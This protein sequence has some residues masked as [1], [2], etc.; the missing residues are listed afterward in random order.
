MVEQAAKERQLLVMTPT[1]HCY[2]D[3]RQAKDL[4]N[5]PRGL[6]ERVVSLE[7]IW[8]HGAALGRLVGLALV[9]AACAAPWTPALLPGLPAGG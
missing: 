3:Y 4:R 5:D 2:L 9:L 1:T 8:R 6:G 7:K